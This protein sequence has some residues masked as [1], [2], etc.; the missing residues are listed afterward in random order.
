M[1]E[2][3]GPAKWE[4]VVEKLMHLG[5]LAVIAGS[6]LFIDFTGRGRLWDKLSGHK[7]S[8]EDAAALSAPTKAILTKDND[9]D[10]FLIHEPASL[11]T[12]P[13]PMAAERAQQPTAAK[14]ASEVPEVQVRDRASKVARPRLSSSLADIDDSSRAATQQTSASA[15]AGSLGHTPSVADTRPNPAYLKEQPEKTKQGAVASRNS[16]GAARVDMMGRSAAPVYN[17]SGNSS[18]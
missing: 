13:A 15:R 5:V 6:F 3:Q 11:P 2:G 12:P 14:L 18:P 1:E 4:I 8:T 9:A 7:V 16:R 17:F 10:R